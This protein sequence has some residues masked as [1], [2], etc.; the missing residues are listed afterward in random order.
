M[1]I[2]LQEV[3]VGDHEVSSLAGSQSEAWADSRRHQSLF[4]FEPSF[5][6]DLNMQCWLEAPVPLTLAP[7]SSQS[8][9]R[10]S[11][12]PGSSGGTTR[13]PQCLCSDK[14]PLIQR[15][16]HLVGDRPPEPGFC[17]LQLDLYFAMVL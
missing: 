17:S 6:W 12:N 3:S 7:R 11:P 10:D 8:K 1:R 16:R 14:W 15:D 5:C 13:N 9:D 4:A 2:L